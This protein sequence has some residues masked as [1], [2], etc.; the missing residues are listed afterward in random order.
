L[1]DQLDEPRLAQSDALPDHAI[2]ALLRTAQ[3]TKQRRD[4]VD[5]VVI[6]ERDGERT[7]FAT[8]A[9]AKNVLPAPQGVRPAITSIVATSTMA[10]RLKIWTGSTSVLRAVNGLVE[11]SMIIGLTA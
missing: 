4:V 1:V 10:L 11:T 2:L 3:I 6:V 5:G 8:K 9:L 7:G